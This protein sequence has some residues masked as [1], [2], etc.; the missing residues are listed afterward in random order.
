KPDRASQLIF[1]VI[2]PLSRLFKRSNAVIPEKFSVLAIFIYLKEIMISPRSIHT[3]R[4][5]AYQIRC[6]AANAVNPFRINI[7]TDT[8]SKSVIKIQG[9]LSMRCRLL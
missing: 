7:L 1:L 4:D 8:L 5:A 9:F 2:H 3:I 6:A